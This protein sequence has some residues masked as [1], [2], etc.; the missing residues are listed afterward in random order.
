MCRAGWCI[1]DT[2]VV[3]VCEWVYE[4]LLVNLDKCVILSPYL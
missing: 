2:T 3:L 1:F 4:L